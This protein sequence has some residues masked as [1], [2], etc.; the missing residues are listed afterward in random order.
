MI[1]VKGVKKVNRV[2]MNRDESEETH[3]TQHRALKVNNR[4]LAHGSVLNGVLT[5]Q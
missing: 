3:G 2:I 5:S 1:A 4:A